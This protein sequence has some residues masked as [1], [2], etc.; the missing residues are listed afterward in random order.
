MLIKSL[1]AFI[2]GSFSIKLLTALS[3]LGV[4]ALFAQQLGVNEFGLLVLCLSMSLLV[5]GLAKLGLENLIVR[6]GAQ[7]NDLDLGRLYVLSHV[8]AL[9]S[10]GLLTL[11]V[12][13]FD[14]QIALWFSV[15]RLNDLLPFICM[16]TLLLALQSINSSILNARHKIIHSV[17]FSGFISNLLILLTALF[18]KP[19]TALHAFKIVLGCTAVSLIFSYVAS[20]FYCTPSF[21]GL[22]TLPLKKLRK[23]NKHYFVIAFSALLTQ[24]L[25]N[26]LVAKYASLA[27]VAM[28]SIALKVAVLFSYP[29][30]AVNAV[31]SPYYARF[32]SA[33]K[34]SNIKQL[35]RETRILLTIIATA[36]ILVVYFC[37]DFMLSLIGEEYVQAAT[38]IKIL[39]IGQW[40]NLS[41]GSA[42]VILLMT[43][44]ER[45][46]QYQNL[47]ITILFLLMLWVLTPIYGGIAAACL[48][49]ASMIAKNLVSL[50][51]VYKR[52]F[53][54]STDDF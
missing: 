27:D 14:T 16:Q 53:K 37:I 18:F 48:V 5:S 42:V 54:M 3:S 31:C 7:F 52:V 9:S 40:V 1:S 26:L 30:Q 46:H 11:L 39:A 32:F 21:D 23:A 25:A 44:H 38:Y 24:Q 8:I 49:A 50:F 10:C 47:F 33:G 36:G 41:C 43:G 12:L 45:I 13:S 22:K 15:E 20:L 2:A 51:V 6:F 4:F 35:A 19:D 28:L 34:F 29:L 17:C